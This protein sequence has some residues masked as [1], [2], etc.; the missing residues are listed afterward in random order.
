MP[1]HHCM[2]ENKI[3]SCYSLDGQPF[4]A[5]W[6]LYLSVLLIVINHDT[7]CYS[8]KKITF[9]KEALKLPL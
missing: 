9:S 5:S 3:T 4:L 1:F 7:A 2:A 8:Q 6:V